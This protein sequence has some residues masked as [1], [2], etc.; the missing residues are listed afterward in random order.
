MVSGQEHDGD[1]ERLPHT[2][3]ERLDSAHHGV[4]L[5]PVHLHLYPVCHCRTSE[6]DD[7]PVEHDVRAVL[8]S[9]TKAA[10]MVP[11]NYD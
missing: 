4:T 5:V 9:Q 2:E 6:Q 10:D 1:V 8:C 11:L 7:A 3:G